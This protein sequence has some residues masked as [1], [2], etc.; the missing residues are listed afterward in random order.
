MATYI[1]RSSSNKLVV[2]EDSEDGTPSPDMIRFYNN[3]F[4]LYRVSPQGGGAFLLTP[5]RAQV[6]SEVTATI[7]TDLVLEDNI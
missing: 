2:T 4:T 7:V 3:G 5:Q 1:A 6:G